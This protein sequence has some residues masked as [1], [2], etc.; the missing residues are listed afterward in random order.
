MARMVSGP[1][2][3]PKA[4]FAA[5]HLRWDRERFGDTGPASAARWSHLV[6]ILAGAVIALALAGA[7]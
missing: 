5:L 4:R 6:A 2:V 1:N 3:L 7:H